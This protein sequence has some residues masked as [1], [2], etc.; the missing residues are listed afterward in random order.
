MNVYKIVN[1]VN[2]HWYIG[3]ESFPDKNYLGSGIAIN[4]AIKK[5]G[6]SSFDK[7]ILETVTSLD[8]LNNR[9]KHWIAITNAQSD[10]TSYNIAAGGNGGDTLSAHPNKKTIYENRDISNNKCKGTVKWFNLLSTVEKKE[11]H[12]NQGL[13]RSKVWVLR[14]IDNPTAE[15]EVVNLREWADNNGLSHSTLAAISTPTSKLY[16]KQHKGWQC[17]RPNDT[18]FPEYQNMRLTGHKS[19]YVNRSWKLVD[20]KRVWC[21]K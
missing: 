4:R 19:P 15:I 16:G 8:E 21:D 17:R 3:K 9:E 18:S 14:K 10:T 6:K 13:T 20:G 12:K 11:F 2:G 7:I 1:R 5:Y